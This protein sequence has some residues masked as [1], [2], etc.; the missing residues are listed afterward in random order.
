MS[1]SVWASSPEAQ[2]A[3]QAERP[4]RPDARAASASAGTTS[5]SSAAKTPQSR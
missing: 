2:P 5:A 1:A 4:S 3:L